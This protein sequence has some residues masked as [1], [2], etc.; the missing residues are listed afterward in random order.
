MQITPYLFY[1]GTCEQALTFYADVLGGTVL[2]KVR[3]SEMPEGERPEGAGDGIANMMIRAAGISIM[4]SDRLPGQGRPMGGFDLHVGV[5]DPEEGERL[6]GAL[7]RGGTIRV[8]WGATSW[9]R[10]FG[11][12]EDRFGTGWMVGCE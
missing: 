10:G 2:G 7:T 8:P 3:Y 12:G 9:A 1:D 4:G 11:T 5:E 6:L